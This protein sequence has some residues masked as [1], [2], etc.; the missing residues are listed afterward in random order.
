[1][2]G[3]VG[4][5]SRSCVIL[6]GVC[7]FVF[8][9]RCVCVGMSLLISYSVHIYGCMDIYVCGYV[10]GPDG[11]WPTIDCRILSALRR[12]GWEACMHAQ[13]TTNR[14]THTHTHTHMTHDT[15]TN[16][17]PTRTT[18]RARRG[19][20][21]WRLLC[22]AHTHTQ[23]DPHIHPSVRPPIKKAHDVF[24][25]CFFFVFLN[26]IYIHDLF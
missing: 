10:E 15:R 17:P 22:P 9:N 4:L 26:N 23:H 12:G 20:P 6:I 16:P 11:Q 13:H 1:M 18:T 25:F 19:W 2:V 7:V 5:S 24:F 8:L 14:H 3:S 21:G